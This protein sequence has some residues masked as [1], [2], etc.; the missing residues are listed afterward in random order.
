MISLHQLITNWDNFFF[1][2]APVY[3][4]ALFR[5]AFGLV[6][7]YEAFFILAN[8]KDYL[9]PNGLV[10]YDRYHKRSE[11][12]YLSV[13]LVLPPT[14]ASVYWVLG[15]HIVF[16]VCMI[17]GL[18]TSV[19]VVCVYVTL[20]SIVN[21][22][23]TICNGGDNVARIMCFFL[24][25]A[26]SGHAYSLD[27]YF[28][29]LHAPGDSAFVLQAP[30]ALRLM[31]VQVSIIYAYTAYWKL[32]GVT[33]RDGTAMYYVMGNH[34]YRRYNLPK[35]LLRKP[36]VQVLTW[37]ALLV[38]FALGF[39]LWISDFTYP[40]LLLGFILHLTIEYILS[41]HLFSW[42]MMAVL[43]L[44]IPPADVAHSVSYFIK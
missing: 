43:L 23:P 15:L 14:M 38:E 28:F 10:R 16:L 34:T 12:R 25:F 13:F 7:L 32:K 21:R 1:S 17:L 33:Y 4:L 42:Y 5:I 40:V 39:G 20:C 24:M 3:T 22:N 9:G 30:W 27:A 19:T 44:F 41:V 8:A 2:P 11:G 18:Y 29:H 36:M 31:Q 6:L 26:S 37:V 35:V